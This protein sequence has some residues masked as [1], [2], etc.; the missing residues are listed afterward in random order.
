ME[1]YT[2]FT[3]PSQMASQARWTPQ[4]WHEIAGSGVTVT[5]SC[6]GATATEFALVAGNDKTRLF[7]SGVAKSEDVAKEAYAAMMKG[8]RM[9]VHGFKN[10]MLLQIQRIS[11]RAMVQ[12]ISAKLNRPAAE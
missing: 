3:Q 1:A 4:L 10:R 5:L 2:V 9:V 6:P 11:P 12:R 7:K 8:R